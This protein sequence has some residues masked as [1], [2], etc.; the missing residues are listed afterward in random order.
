MKR[1]GITG[2]DGFIGKHL[3]NTLELFPDEFERID[4]KK[5]LFDSPESLD[6]FVSRCDVIVHLAALNRHNDPQVIYETNTGLVKSLIAVFG[7]HQ[8]HGSCNIFV[9]LPGRTG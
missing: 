1:V 7:T 4:F 6:S 5:S 3:Y 2:Q 9:F 8:K